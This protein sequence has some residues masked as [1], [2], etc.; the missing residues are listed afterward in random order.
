[1]TAACIAPNPPDTP[2]APGC[3]VLAPVHTPGTPDDLTAWAFAPH[4]AKSLHYAEAALVGYLAEVIVSAEWQQAGGVK[5][6]THW[7]TLRTGVSPGRA[8]QLLA[9]ARRAHELP[10]MMKE[11]TDATI[12]LDHALTIA[13]FTPTGYDHD[14]TKLAAKLT[15]NQLRRLLRNYVWPHHVADDAPP[16]AR[17]KTAPSAPMAV[18]HDDP[19]R[20]ATFTTYTRRGRFHAHLDCPEADGALI[21][22]ALQHTTEA[23]R[24]AIKCDESQGE[25]PVDAPRLSTPRVTAAEALLALA[26]QTLSAVDPVSSRAAHYR[27]YIHL[28]TRGASFTGGQ[29]LPDHVADR[30]TCDG[31]CQPVWETDGVPVS[32]GREQRIVPARTKRL[33]HHRD[34]GCR[35]PGCTNTRYLEAHHIQHWRDGGPTDMNNLVL[36]CSF[37][38]DEHHKG[39]FSIQGDPSTPATDGG[40]CTEAG[41]VFR[42]ANNTP[43]TFTPPEGWQP[44]P[45]ST[46]PYHPPTGGSW[47]N[48]WTLFHPNQE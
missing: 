44:P 36:L 25:T 3:V 40:T 32:V 31:V 13:T 39:T 15:V 17:V 23:L 8:N 14:V 47:D 34:R 9:V 43:I 19:D 38:H 37:H 41:L 4:L 28:D 24:D 11:F 42:Y 20:P 45:P 46:D 2:V 33:L 18:S 16:A 26:T 7:V 48:R 35:F 1:M 30:L 10:H 12:S 29:L 6:L 22:Q 5:T 21:T 27:T